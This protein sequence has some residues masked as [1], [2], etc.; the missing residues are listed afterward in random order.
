MAKK[1]DGKCNVLL[2]LAEK[3]PEIGEKWNSDGWTLRVEQW[4]GISSKG[5]AW[6]STKLAKRKMTFDEDGA[7][8][9]TSG[10]GL[11]LDDLNLVQQNWAQITALL[12]NPPDAEEAAKNQP[13]PEKAPAKPEPPAADD[14]S[15]VPF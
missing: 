15:E 11:S 1:F 2:L 5:K 14:D 9:T 4:F 8:I 3:R 6:Q 10:Q 13:A 12:A 7:V